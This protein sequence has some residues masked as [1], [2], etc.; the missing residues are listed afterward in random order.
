[1]IST[2]LNVVIKKGS[3]Q[4][5]HLRVW[6]VKSGLFCCTNYWPGEALEGSTIKSSNWRNRKPPRV[7]S[8]GIGIDESNGSPHPLAHAVPQ[9]KYFALQYN[10]RTYLTA[11]CQMVCR[12]IKYHII[13]NVQLFY[14]TR[15]VRVHHGK[16]MQTQRSL[17]LDFFVN[18]SASCVTHTYIDQPVSLTHILC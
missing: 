4:P 7:F 16:S 8:Q 1:M 12:T 17:I 18:W 13:V 14:S 6:R 10:S 11:I 15:H 2:G 3:I 9:K 5:F